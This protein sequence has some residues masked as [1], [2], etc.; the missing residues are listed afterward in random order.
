MIILDLDGVC[1]NFTHAACTVHG[2]T[3]YVATKWNFFEDWDLTP[4]QFWEPIHL[5][6][7]TF[8]R[9]IVRPYPWLAELIAAVEEADDWVIMS[10]PSDNSVGYAGK[11]I[12]VDKY[13][14]PLVKKRVKLIVGSEK[15]LLAGP[16]RILIDDYE[17]NLTDFRRAS[18]QTLTF[19]RLWNNMHSYAGDPVEFVK[20][21]LHYWKHFEVAMR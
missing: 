14:Q 21:G 3:E 9:H 12:W 15:H 7:D 4:K 18:G 5:Y 13:I 2:H 20:Q 8:Y 17:E 1:A 11:K 16:N 6:G 19:P 10:S